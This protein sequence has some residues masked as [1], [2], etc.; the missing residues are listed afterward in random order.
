MVME[1]PIPVGIVH[2]SRLIREEIGGLLNQRIGAR[3][4]GTF[5]GAREIL[6]RAPEQEFVLIYH[7]GTAHQDG[8]QGGAEL[9][10]RLPQAKIL[11]FDVVDNDQAIIE[12]V[13]M[14]ASGCL[15]QDATLV[16][17]LEA[18]RSVWRGAPVA[19]SR[20]ISAMLA[21]VAR[22]HAPDDFAP[23]VPLTARE[24]QILQFVAEGLSN[25]EIATRL[26]LQP[27]TVKNYVHVVLRKLD[28]HRRRE[29]M[30]VW[31]PRHTFHAA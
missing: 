23:S 17:L 22:L 11:M 6:Q 21:Y 12:C 29:V 9:Y 7:Y 20:C 19:P 5:G 2:A 8:R 10:N 15:L 1:Q 13:R 26:H 25:K 30:R 28:L 18:V 31:Q 16:E 24:A 14:G 4:A 3:S 27:Q